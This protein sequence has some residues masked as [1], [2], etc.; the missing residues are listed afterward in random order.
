MPLRERA[1]LTGQRSQALIPREGVVGQ[2]QLPEQTLHEPIQQVVLVRHVT[3]ESHRGDAQ[4]AGDEP[5]RQSLEALTL[6]H[7]ECCLEH[8][9]PSQRQGSVR[10]T[11]A[12]T[13]SENALYVYGVRTPTIDTRESQPGATLRP[14]ASRSS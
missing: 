10:C 13:V 5:H 12:G 1:E 3:V 8:S 11:H 6:S 14:C 2:L 9:L 4:L 7:C